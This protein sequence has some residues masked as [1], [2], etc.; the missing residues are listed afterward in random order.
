MLLESMS[1]GH[2][3]KYS[4]VQLKHSD[5]HCGSLLHVYSGKI[6]LPQQFHTITTVYSMLSCDPAEISVARCQLDTTGA[7][8]DS[9]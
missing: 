6:Q 8:S 7:G 1:K 4:V 3:L 9:Q 5:L 2:Q